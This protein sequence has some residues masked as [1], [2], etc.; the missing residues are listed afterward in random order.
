ME[1][2]VRVTVRTDEE[3]QQ[4]RS[5]LAQLRA[6][7]PPRGF[8]TQDGTRTVEAVFDGDQRERLDELLRGT[9]LPYVVQA[10]DE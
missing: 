9:G 7:P 5:M 1:T 2:F 6:A 10:D 4:V 3:V 8:E